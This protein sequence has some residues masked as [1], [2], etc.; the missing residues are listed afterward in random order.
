MTAD[1]NFPE[2]GGQEQGDAGLWQNGEAAAQG[3]DAYYA[4]ENRLA[5]LESTN[6]ALIEKISVLEAR[7]NDNAD[8][9]ALAQYGPSG[10]EVN[11]KIAYFESRLSQDNDL[12]G[13]F[14]QLLEN[15]ARAND[16]RVEDLRK[17]IAALSS[18][19]E[20]E[21]RLAQALSVIGGKVE[22]FSRAAAVLGPGAERMQLEARQKLQE[23]S[24][25]AASLDSM[26]EETALLRKQVEELNRNFSSKMEER[27][28]TA[29]S[30]L[31][32][33]MD[34]SMQ[35]LKKDLLQTS[36]SAVEQKL[37][38]NI[39]S[40][41]KRLDEFSSQ[42]ARV[43]ED[44]D[45][46]LRRELASV[47]ETFREQAAQSA[48]ELK[49]SLSTD[50]LARLDSSAQRADTMARA[51]STVTERLSELDSRLLL[52]ESAVRAKMAEAEARLAKV[53]ELAS[54]VN[55]SISREVAAATQRGAADVARCNET[56]AQLASRL[57]EMQRRLDGLQ[58][59]AGAEALSR[60]AALEARVEELNE[61]SF[62]TVSQVKMMLNSA[63]GGWDEFLAVPSHV[64]NMGVELSYVA[65]KLMRIQM[66]MDEF[67]AR[68]GQFLVASK[69]ISMERQNFV[70]YLKAQLGHTANLLTR[71]ED[72]R[73]IEHK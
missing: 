16:S 34:D 21:Q 59:E 20:V 6:A 8:S 1:S 33:E 37:D 55:A 73:N 51:V 22:A 58:S 69:Q 61:L 70:D 3:A 52:S 40:F 47:S 15:A 12:A 9:A 35:A 72:E 43:R 17:E 57:E 48:R 60:T 31:M 19:G 36:A 38:G 62:Q 45:A 10:E 23:L 30:M 28:R 32:R 24:D 14:A 50:M 68:F 64:K 2:N 27:I 49:S 39:L 41:K 42:I 44:S 4:V 13:R 25:K 53:G 63:Q 46:A 18:R 54:G 56:I 71:L 67:E 26:R 5:E 11:R 29:S 66:R 65:N 7:L